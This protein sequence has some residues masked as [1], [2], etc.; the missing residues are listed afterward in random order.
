MH[1]FFQTMANPTCTNG[2]T[3]AFMPTEVPR[4]YPWQCGPDKGMDE[5]DLET[6][7]GSTGDKNLLVEEHIRD[8]SLF[9]E[10][11]RHL[12]NNRAPGPDEVNNELLKAPA[13]KHAPSHPQAACAH[14]ADWHHARQLEGVQHYTAA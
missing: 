1:K 14:V 8:H 3:G 12:S 13:T 11:V 5:F 4:E 10:I 9:Q 7:V 2:K 6:K